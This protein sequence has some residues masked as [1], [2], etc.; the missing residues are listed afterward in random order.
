MH[1]AV[2]GRSLNSSPFDSGVPFFVAS[3]A[4]TRFRFLMVVVVL[5]GKWGACLEWQVSVLVYSVFFFC[6]CFFDSCVQ[7]SS[8]DCVSC[9]RCFSHLDCGHVDLVSLFFC[10]FFDHYG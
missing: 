8:V 5:C 9:L 1:F 6:C 4:F 3:V 2:S 10:L 7:F